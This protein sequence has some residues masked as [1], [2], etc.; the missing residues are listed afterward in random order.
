MFNVSYD[1]KLLGNIVANTFLIWLYV[2]DQKKQSNL[3]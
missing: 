2:N 3:V 1:E